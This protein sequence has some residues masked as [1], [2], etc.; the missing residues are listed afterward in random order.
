MI[1][2]PPGRTRTDVG[3]AAAIRT[4]LAELADPERAAGMAGY[5]QA[6][7][8]GYGEGDRFLGIAVPPQRAVAKRPAMAIPRSRRS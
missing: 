8:G 6:R 4:E 1:D 3:S 2:R 5:F 7:P